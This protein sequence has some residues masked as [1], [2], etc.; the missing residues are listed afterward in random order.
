MTKRTK[1]NAIDAFLAR[2]AE[3]DTLLEKLTAKSAEHFD[4]APSDITWAN[5]GSLEHAADQ[6]RELAKFLN[7]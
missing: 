5:V 1:E 4:T 7:A 6:L 2:K 3:I